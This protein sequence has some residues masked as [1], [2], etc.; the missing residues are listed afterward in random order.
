LISLVR[1]QALGKT[2]E[3]EK[4]N[5]QIS[6]VSRKKKKASLQNIQKLDGKRIL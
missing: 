3:E 5:E 2:H 1:W 4:T 6:L